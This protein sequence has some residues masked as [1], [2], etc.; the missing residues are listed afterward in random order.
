[1]AEYYH[2]PRHG[3]S[4]KH[5]LAA[6][7]FITAALLLSACGPS[8]TATVSAAVPPPAM[9]V[10]VI[11]A[12]TADVPLRN[13]W[14]GT[15]DG[16]VNAQIQPQV[17]GYLVRQNYRE[18]Q[19]V[20]KGQV[21]FEIDPRPLRAAVDQVKGQIGQAQGQTAEAEGQLAQAE[22][23]LRLA[24]IN[25][26]RDAPLAAQRAISQSQL[27]NDKQQQAQAE[28]NVKT[29]KGAIAA[30]QAAVATARAN[31]DTAALNLDF[32]EV[33]SLISGVAGQAATQV[34]N[35]VGPQ[36]VLTS[37]SQLDPIKVYFS[38]SDEEY[39]SF[40]KNVGGKSPDLL[41]AN[42]PLSLTLADGTIYPHRGHID[43][44][45]RQMNQ[46]TGA[47]RI[48]AAFP[49][50]GNVLRP[51]QFG[52]VEATARVLHDAILVPQIAVT[53]LQGLKQ[54]HTVDPAGRVHVVNVAL[55][56]QYGNDWV[57]NTGLSP[58]A[59]V[60]TDNLQKLAEGM[61]VK[62]HPAA[63]SNTPPQN[64]QGR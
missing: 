55:G 62:P 29:A 60:I 30:G 23:Q 28:A 43:F 49:N 27:D 7:S 1:M 61:P 45:D 13:E 19:V 46:Q 42:V 31:A 36:S 57:V 59:K 32:T 6:V 5:Q 20:S 64:G 21:L 58:G 50:P 15:L 33:R 37:V 10:S 41:T 17:S 53:D 16:Y 34:G 8:N 18:G 54:V 12:K 2:A 47:I 26:D 39:L 14:V 51:G 40:A 25:V 63:A 38:I 35:L 56:P 52:R 44:V 48:A 3:A 11:E 22:A 24:Q 4:K 9:P